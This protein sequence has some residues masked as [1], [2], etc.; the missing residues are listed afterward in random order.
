[1]ANNRKTIPENLAADIIFQSDFTCCV[2]REREKSVQMV[3]MLMKIQVI[4]SLKTLYVFV[5]NVITQSHIRGGVDRKSDIQSDY[6]V[7]VMNG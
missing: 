4:T 6:K 2:C 3:T 7:S 1:M 5:L